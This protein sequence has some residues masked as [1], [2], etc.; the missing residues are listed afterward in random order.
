MQSSGTNLENGFATSYKVKYIYNT[1]PGNLTPEHF[2]K[3][4]N[5]LHSH[6]R[7]Y[8]NVH[9]SFVAIEKL[10]D[11]HVH[12]KDKQIVYFAHQGISPWQ[13]KEKNFGIMLSKK[14]LQKVTYCAGPLPWHSWTD[15]TI[16]TENRPVVYRQELHTGG[17]RGDLY[18]GDMREFFPGQWNCSVSW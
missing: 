2:P 9:S 1:W 5:N 14:Q 16:A 18:R 13:Y 6:R 3:W 10:M 11:P 15:K 12:A 17:G 7:L 8:P 4:N